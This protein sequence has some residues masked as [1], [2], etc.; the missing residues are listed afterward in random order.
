[1]KLVYPDWEKQLIWKDG[2]FPLAVLENPDCYFRIA[3]EL[4]LASNGADSRF[5]LSDE[6]RL[7]DLSRSLVTVPSPWSMV[8]DSRKL[9]TAL[10]S[11]LKKEWVL[12][13]LLGASREA[14]AAAS[15]CAE[16]A[17]D[18]FSF[19]LIY[20]EEGDPMAP[21]KAV[22][23]RP[24]PEEGPLAERMLSYM[25]LCTDLLGTECFAFCSFRGFLSRESLQE[26]Y[27]TASLNQFRFFLLESRADY[28]LE[29]ENPLTIDRDLC[30]IF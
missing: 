18:L 3:E 12:P 20:D 2:R 8:W 9:M 29:E 23:L 27:R 25:N 16:A 14:A 1:M 30:Q 10:Y 17:S 13:E 7:L 15:R 21:L 24:E 11:R 28:I 5:V 19:P 4:Y 26:L 22:R 6:G